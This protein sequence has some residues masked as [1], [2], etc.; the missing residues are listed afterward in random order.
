M[1][2]RGHGPSEDNG[3]EFSKLKSET[4]HLKVK[5]SLLSEENQSLIKQLIKD[6]EHANERVFLLLQTLHPFPPPS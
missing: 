4:D 2:S 6:H 5:N 1:I 3:A